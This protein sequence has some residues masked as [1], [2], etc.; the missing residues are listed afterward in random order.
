MC[1]GSKTNSPLFSALLFFALLPCAAGVLRA[2]E[3][4]QYYL[5]SETELQAIE[6]HKATSETERRSWLLQ[7]QSLKAQSASLNDQLASQRERNKNLE[8]SFN[9]LEADRSARLSS[10]NGEIAMLKKELA[11]K[12]LE[13]QSHKQASA[14]RLAIIIAIAA[15][16]IGH[17]A[18]KAMRFLR[19]IPF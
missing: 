9:E 12:T 11:D 19:I 14:L 1:A 3:P 7:A 4:L 17:A 8:L 10:L 6:R 18:F 2:E 5:I 15:A 16:I 13:A